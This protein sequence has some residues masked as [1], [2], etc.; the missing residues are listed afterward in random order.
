MK[1]YVFETDKWLESEVLYPHDIAL[2]LVPETKTVYVWT[3]SRT[4]LNSKNQSEDA[5]NHLKEKYPDYQFEVVD[6]STP[7]SVREFIEQFVNT[8]FEE[9]EKIDRD[10]QFVVFYYM[11][12]GLFLG[13]IVTYSMIF[14]IMGWNKV[15]DQALLSISTT[16]F[17]NW[18]Y[19]NFII[20]I[21]LASLFLVSLAFAALTKKI[22]LI[23][24][25]AIGMVVLVGTMLYFRLGVFLFD[26]KAGAP[27]GYYYISI[28]AVFGFIVLNLVALGVILTPMII[29]VFAIRNTTTPIT[30]DEWKEK[31]KKKVLEMKKFSVLDVGS[32]FTEL[33]H[34]HEHEES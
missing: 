17:A 3:G 13:L 9:I 26:F 24:T 2:C 20:S 11:M 14:R 28:G 31:R 18:A 33:E 25:A 19:Q 8:S 30:W 22:F 7:K 15:P 27:S 1:L 34:E 29:S 5:L 21:V 10:P 6:E 4:P 23:I 32:D 16:S 12:F